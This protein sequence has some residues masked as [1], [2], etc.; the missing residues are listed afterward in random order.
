MKSEKP[1]PLKDKTRCGILV[2]SENTKLQG[3]IS[4]CLK[5]RSETHSHP[6]AQ[7]FEYGVL[8]K[9]GEF[10]LYSEKD[11]RSAVQ[12]LLDYFDE[13]IKMHMGDTQG[14]SLI[15][16]KCM[17]KEAFPDVVILEVKCPICKR[18]IHQR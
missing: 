11:V 16:G 18:A 13:K 14:A 7:I 15:I 12:W 4:I 1:E 6:E 5:K 10:Y 2:A 17:V 3:S 8:K 9:E